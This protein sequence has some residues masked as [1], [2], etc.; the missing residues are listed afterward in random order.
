MNKTPPEQSRG[1]FSSQ[2]MNN[3]SWTPLRLNVNTVI[4]FS[5]GRKKLFNDG[6]LHTEISALGKRQ[7]FIETKNWKRQNFRMSLKISAFT[8]LISNNQNSSSEGNVF[9]SET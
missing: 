8:I 2:L 5:K 6:T 3:N 1:S 9:M 7:F 4:E